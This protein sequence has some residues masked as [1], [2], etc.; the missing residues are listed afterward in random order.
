[1]LKIYFAAKNDVCVYTGRLYWVI[2][3][4][5][6]RKVRVKKYPQKLPAKK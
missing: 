2:D 4:H 1:L 3:S 5:Q 6:Q